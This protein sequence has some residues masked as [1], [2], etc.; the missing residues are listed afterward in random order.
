MWE[1]YIERHDELEFCGIYVDEGLSGTSTKNRVGFNQMIRDASL[2]NFDLI[3]TKEVS[4]FAR[5]TVDTLQ[6]TRLLR[7]YN[8]NVYF[9]IDNINTRDNDGELR[10]SLMATLAQEESRKISERVKLG[11]MQA[12]KSGVVFGSDRI[13]G[14]NLVNKK[15]TINEEEAD[16][17][18]NIFKWYLVDDESL[19][20]IVRRLASIGITKGKAGGIINHSTIKRILQNEKYVGD[21]KQKKYYTINYL[22]HARKKNDGK[23]QEFI[24]IRDNHPSII[25]RED[26]NNVQ[27]KL[28]SNKSKYKKFNIGYSKSLFS[29]KILCGNCGN[30]YRKRTLKNTDGTNRVIYKCNANYSKGTKGCKNGSYIREDVLINIFIELLVKITEDK[31]RK[32]FIKNMMTA[33]GESL[34]NEVIN[35][36]IENLEEQ[37]KKIQDKKGK[38]LDLY[39]DEMIDKKGYNKKNIELTHS[40]SRLNCKLKEIENESIK[41]TCK[42]DRLKNLYDILTKELDYKSIDELENIKVLVDNYVEKI[43]ILGKNIKFHMIDGEYEISTSKYPIG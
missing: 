24:I 33:L 26:F 3:M 11:H 32:V 39:M 2:G 18:R 30:K 35:Q 23:V 6:Y 29:G 20:G 15:L 19:H 12:M 34:N 1:E 40:Q 7:D 36:D 22:T 13:L 8:V 17:V 43:V 41:L 25:N 28:K 16:V 27:I 42:K 37:I 31:N 4:R 38:L 9:K 21:L 5:N 14:Y 10:L